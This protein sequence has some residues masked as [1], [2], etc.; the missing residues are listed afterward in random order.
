MYYSNK[1]FLDR[2]FDES[3]QKKYARWYAQYEGESHSEKTVI[4]QYT[5]KGRIRGI[6][7]DVN[8]NMAY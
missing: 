4:W 7:G 1:D 3:L 2:M 5:N 8:E 6:K